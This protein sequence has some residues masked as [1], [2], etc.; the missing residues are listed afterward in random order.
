M[1]KTVLLEQLPL[2]FFYLFLTYSA[3]S[4]FETKH[5]LISPDMKPNPLRHSI[6]LCYPGWN[7]T[8]SLTR[9]IQF[10]KVLPKCISEK[11]CSI[12]GLFL[13][14]KTTA[15][16]NICV[17]KLLSEHF[18]WQPFPLKIQFLYSLLSCVVLRGGPMVDTEVTTFGIQVY[19]SLDFCWEF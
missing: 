11:H 16:Q 17:V 7:S 2:P 1:L 10:F 5:K 19:R 13:Q 15:L 3:S 14:Q 6:D 18:C 12:G 9:T 4:L 8:S